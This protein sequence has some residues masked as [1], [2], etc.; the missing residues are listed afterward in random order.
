MSKTITYELT[1]SRQR[2]AM[3]RWQDDLQREIVR[4][5]L[6]INENRK[7]DTARWLGIQR[8]HLPVLMRRLG[9]TEEKP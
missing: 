4:V 2:G 1:R 5:A 6:A 3:A 7:A 9:L 8:T